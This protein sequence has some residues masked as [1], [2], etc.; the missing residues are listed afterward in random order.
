MRFYIFQADD[1][2]SGFSSSAILHMQPNGV[3]SY[4]DIKSFSDFVNKQILRLSVFVEYI[5]N[6]KSQE[7]ST[8]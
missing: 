2:A 5:H 3:S 6:T 7:N 1:Q 8:F 4:K